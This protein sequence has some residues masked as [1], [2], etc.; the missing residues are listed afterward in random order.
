M[1]F[2]GFHGTISS[3]LSHYLR[4]SFALRPPSNLS[5]VCL[6]A[7]TLRAQGVKT[8]TTSHGCLHRPSL[9]RNAQF[10]KQEINPLN[11]SLAYGIAKWLINWFIYSLTKWLTG[12]FI[13]T[14]CLVCR[15][16]WHTVFGSVSLWLNPWKPRPSCAGARKVCKRTCLCSCDERGAASTASFRAWQSPRKY[17]AIH[18]PP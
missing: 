16:S 17:V 14:K 13:C 15:F 2:V 12:S 4:L 7:S 6:K 11:K 3:W 9:I 5:Q 1:F 10:I 8:T 18:V